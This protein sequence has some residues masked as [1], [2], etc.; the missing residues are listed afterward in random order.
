MT[1]IPVDFSPI[2]DKHHLRAESC[3]SDVN[4]FGGIALAFICT[5]REGNC[6]LEAFQRVEKYSALTHIGYD[7]AEDINYFLMIGLD[8]CPGWDWEYYFRI[9]QVNGCNNTE[10]PIFDALAVSEIIKKSDKA[11]VRD[12]LLQAS[13][14]LINSIRPSGFVMTTRDS[15]LP[16]KAMEKYYQL[17]QVFIGCGYSVSKMD[18][19]HGRQAWRMVCNSGTAIVMPQFGG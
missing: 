15:F 17:C 2:V 10:E 12:L 4:R 7:G 11:K 8:E 14:Y 1:N 9:I 3:A 19:Y 5:V 16:G 13:G 18:P 6:S